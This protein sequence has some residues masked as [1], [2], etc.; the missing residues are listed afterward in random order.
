MSPLLRALSEFAHG[1]ES[2]RW[3][4]AWR[5]L[6]SLQEDASDE[7][8][9]TPAFLTAR[10]HALEFVTR[11]MALELAS[12]A[13]HSHDEETAH[14]LTLAMVEMNL[15]VEEQPVWLETKLNHIWDQRT[16]TFGTPDIHLP[17]SPSDEAAG[18][19]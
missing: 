17:R 18:D 7:G 19:T 2:A 4:G 3:G 8:R 6:A 13:R 1:Q 10:S 16:T 9:E 14:A 5:L 15:S 12:Y 11:L